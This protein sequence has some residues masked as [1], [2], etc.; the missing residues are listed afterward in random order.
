MGS[1][2]PEPRSAHFPEGDPVSSVREI[3]SRATPP[4]TN[5]PNIPSTPRRDSSSALSM[6]AEA[7]PEARAILLKELEGFIEK[8]A[9]SRVT[10]LLNRSLSKAKCK[11]FLNSPE[12]QAFSNNSWIIPEN[13]SAEPD[14]YEPIRQVVDSII[15]YFGLAESRKVHDT[16]KKRLPSDN[17]EALK[18]SP[19]LFVSASGPHFRRT[20]EDIRWSQCLTTIEVKQQ[21]HKQGFNDIISQTAYNARQ[22][23][24][25][26]PT[27]S[28]VYKLLM[29]ESRVRLL[30]FDR[31]GAL[32]SDW[33]NYRKNP[34]QLVRLVYLVCNPNLK[35][36]GIDESVVFENDRLKFTM[37]R[38]GKPF[39]L[40]ADPIPRFP[41]MGLCGRA[42]VCWSVQDADG[43]PYL[44][45]QQFV[46]TSR[47]L[48]HKIL[49]DIQTK[50]D[51]DLSAIGTYVFS[52]VYRT[53]SANRGMTMIPETFHDRY[54]YRIVLDEH[55]DTIDQVEDK[56]R[57]DLLVALRDAILGHQSLWKQGILHRDIST[58]NILYRMKEDAEATLRGVLIDFD[59]AINIHRKRSNLKA[60]FRTGTRAFQSVMV[61]KSYQPTNDAGVLLPTVLHDHLDDLESFFWVLVWITRQKLPAG[62][63]PDNFI[64]SLEVRK[65][66]EAEAATSASH[67]RDFLD[68][69]DEDLVLLQPGWGSVIRK[70]ISN[71]AHFFHDEFMIKRKSVNGNLKAM[72]PEE[73]VCVSGAHY[74][75]VIKYFE[76]A[77]ASLKKEMEDDKKKQNSNGQSVPQDH[78]S[79]TPKR[80]R[81]AEPEDAIIATDNIAPEFDARATKRARTTKPEPGS[82]K[83]RARSTSVKSK[84]GTR[85]QKVQ[86]NDNSLDGELRADAGSS[87][88][89]P[90]GSRS[91]KNSS[92]KEPR[93]GSR[94]SQRLASKASEALRMGSTPVFEAKGILTQEL[95]G[96]IVPFQGSRA[97]TLLDNTLTS[98]QCAAFFASPEANSLFSDN[99]WTMTETPSAESA[100]YEPILSIV[101]AVLAH[102]G[103]NNSR[104]IHNT[105]K[106]R[107]IPTETA[108]QLKSSPDLFVSVSGEH[109]Q[110]A[111][112]GKEL[113]W[114]QETL[115]SQPQ[116]SIVYSILMTEKRA[117]LLSFDRV[118]VQYSKWIDFRETPSQLIRLI[119]FVC[120]S[121]LQHLGI[122]TTAIFREDGQLQFTLEHEGQPYVVVA[123]P[124]P[125]T[126]PMG[127]RGRATVCWTVKGPNDEPYVLKQQFVNVCR[128]PEHEILAEIQEF[129]DVDL[130]SVGVFIV[131]Q[132]YGRVSEARGMVDVP[133]TFHDRYLYRLVLNE[134][135]DPIDDLEGKTRMDL[136][137]ALRDAITGHWA[138]WQKDILHRDIST[139][140][141]LYRKK[142]EEDTSLRGVLIDFDM[143]DLI[144]RIESNHNA[145]FRTGTRAFQSISVLESYRTATD[146]GIP[147]PNILHDHLDDLESFFW[148]LIWITRENVAPGTDVS[149]LR[150]DI[151]VREDFEAAAKSAAAQKLLLL[152]RYRFLGLQDGWGEACT[153]LCISLGKFFLDQF[154]S[155]TTKLNGQQKAKTPQEAKAESA[156]HYTEI[157]GYFDLAIAALKEETEDTVVAPS[158]PLTDVQNSRSSPTSE[159]RS[160][161]ISLPSSK[162]PAPNF[163]QPS[164][165]RTSSKRTREPELVPTAGTSQTSVAENYPNPDVPIVPPTKRARTISTPVPTTRITRSAS[166]TNLVKP[167]TRADRSWFFKPYYS[168]WWSND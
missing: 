159:P 69:W 87:R 137:V 110:R 37:K 25:A 49:D 32:Y 79:A 78:G 19:D 157:L 28:F 71:L 145:D 126:I 77:I 62:E 17:V 92:K 70:L 135:G 34:E 155:K 118:G 130:S 99:K 29:T 164:P 76:D 58:K 151:L 27:R 42:T 64:P 22:T 44:L 10:R 57:L 104:K 98:D 14:L 56:S 18:C 8:F 143:A 13:P 55:G 156:A 163:Q 125:R 81:E 91:R 66:F 40:T 134:H 45:K 80:S 75:T 101:K 47:E 152:Y 51:V 46:N 141:I 12:Q 2:Q 148:V 149:A 11:A 160:R 122:D 31:V 43:N 39:I 147:L 90:S 16:S 119:H 150:K 114:F 162:I 88:G 153:N 105:S 68:D 107:R 21:G 53:V 168:N 50:E 9:P 154:T 103:L 106:V 61:L 108:E 41:P 100:L 116:R 7:I 85:G 161:A 93:V 124:T 112:P 60:D 111:P 54:M 97:Q 139:N 165:T 121:D 127:L 96:F 3:P 38:D 140:N 15:S 52:Q 30:S 142:T 158:S 74:T 86:E 48:E 89:R 67:K 115:T 65:K 36:L 117:R 113:H 4:P 129:D 23:L 120:C 166:K 63:D 1:L 94:A 146:S 132:A 20:L 24:T 109:F 83:Q 133:P 33:I 102:F 5:K 136:L 95:E 73:L 131:A 26:Q 167:R 35:S 84:K 59:L 138:L 72:T 6:G 144:N 128:P 123:D 82:T